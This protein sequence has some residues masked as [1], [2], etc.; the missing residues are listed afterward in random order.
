MSINPA[1]LAYLTKVDKLIEQLAHPWVQT[2]QTFCCHIKMTELLCSNYISH[3]INL[4]RYWICMQCMCCSFWLP[5]AYIAYTL[6]TINYILVLLVSSMFSS[7]HGSHGFFLPLCLVNAFDPISL[8]A[9]HKWPILG[10]WYIWYL[11]MLEDFY[12]NPSLFYR[13]GLL[14]LLN[15]HETHTL[16]LSCSTCSNQT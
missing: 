14:Y 11:C 15:L 10:I 6:Y 1:Y 4:I 3:L 8:V 12:I 7:C 5:F 16:N 13:H 2:V 9:A